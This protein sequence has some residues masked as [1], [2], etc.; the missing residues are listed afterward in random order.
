MQ[1]FQN[2][3]P[4]VSFNIGTQDGVKT[5]E[6]LSRKSKYFQS[7]LKNKGEKEEKIFK[8]L[9]TFDLGTFEIQSIIFYCSSNPLIIQIDASLLTLMN[10]LL[11]FSYYIFP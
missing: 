1:M 2:K 7:L 10:L 4:K 9:P 11:F 8:E 6:I 3:T 5:A